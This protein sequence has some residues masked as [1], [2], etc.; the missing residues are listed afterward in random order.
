MMM[1]DRHLEN[2]KYYTTS[3]TFVISIHSYFL[4]TSTSTAKNDVISMDL[5]GCCINVYCII[6]NSRNYNQL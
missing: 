4:T 6:P 5:V 1:R 3:V 2:Y